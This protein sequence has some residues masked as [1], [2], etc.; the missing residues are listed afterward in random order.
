MTATPETGERERVDALFN[1][2]SSSRTPEEHMGEARHLI[3][4]AIKSLQAAASTAREISERLERTRLP[5]GP[6][7][8]L[9]PEDQIK[10]DAFVNGDGPRG[11]D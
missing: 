1:P 4:R 8:E 2:P 3:D 9:L 6:A 7:V 5:N 11:A 10:A